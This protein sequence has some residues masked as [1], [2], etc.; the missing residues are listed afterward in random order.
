MRLSEHLRVA[1][2][3][4]PRPGL[5]HLTVIEEAHRLLRRSEPGTAGPAAHAVEMFAAMLAE[6]RAYGEGL[7][8][9]EQ[10]P[11][12][13]T[14]D[15]IKNTAVKIVHRLPAKDDRDS[16]GATMNVTD[17]Q[18][19]YIVTLVPGEGAVFT[20][21]M[22]RPL[23]VR[24]PDGSTLE[25]S[26]AGQVAP[27]DRLIGRRSD[28]CGTECQTQ[29]CTLRQMRTAAHLLAAEPWLVVWA[30]LTVLAHLTGQPVPVPT[31]EVRSAFVERNL[32]SRLV[33]CAL[34]H[35]VDDAV[36]VRSAVMSPTTDPAALAG[37]V[38]AVITGMLRGEPSASQ[39]DDL[40]YL[41]TPFRW[42]Q[43]RRALDA[44]QDP[45]RDP[46]SAEWE[47]RFH[48]K[49]PGSSR[50]EQLVAVKEWLVRDLADTTAVDAVS[51]GTRRPS[52]IERAVGTATDGRT[53]RLKSTLE[54]FIDC[55]WPLIHFRPN[56]QQSG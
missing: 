55:T 37:H 7:I 36:A 13:L 30:E 23:L 41:A 43:V 24:V 8:I 42:E 16:V 10:I 9:A 51:Y 29:A 33:D 14:P 32:P 21:G 46:R 44:G 4:N 1:A 11:S 6:V 15:V 17:E 25:E 19:R 22:D 35:A 5:T 52:A 31:A 27:V 38:R 34:S 28:T 56:N 26:T 18:S 20:D 54:Q 53:E 3:N 48:R 39:A 47:A 45:G 12:K 40:A 50:V 49:I 2:R